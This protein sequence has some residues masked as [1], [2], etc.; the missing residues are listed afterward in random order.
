MSLFRERLT[1]NEFQ[2]VGQEAVLSLI[3][4]AS[5]VRDK[6]NLICNEKNIST[7]QYN[8]LRILKGS[9]PQSYPRFEIS[10]RMVEKSPDITRTIDRMVKNGLVERNK[11]T[12]DMRQSI[13]K[14]TDK[15]IK[16]L[17]ELNTSIHSFQNDFQ[18]KISKK[19]CEILSA[20]CDSILLLE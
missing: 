16:L 13:A 20:I 15:G 1:Q 11:S 9:Y 17:M 7:A 5:A 8:I 14:I 3:A 4:A 10:S 18:N 12:D 19:Q 2:N 6:L